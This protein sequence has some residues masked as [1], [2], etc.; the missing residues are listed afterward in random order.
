MSIFD[1]IYNIIFILILVFIKYTGL[2][3]GSN[4]TLTRIIIL[5]PLSLTIIGFVGSYIVGN[6]C[7]SSHGNIGNVGNCNGLNNALSWMKYG[8]VVYVVMIPII[9]M[10][11]PALLGGLLLGSLFSKKSANTSN[12]LAKPANSNNKNNNLNRS[13]TS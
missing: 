13:K 2:F 6:D 3:D 8:I 10:S 9:I 1:L 5:L 11:V 7:G 4:N 12:P